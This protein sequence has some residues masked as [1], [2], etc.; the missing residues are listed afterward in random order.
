MKNADPIV[1]IVDDDPAMRDSMQL[2]VSRMGVEVRTYDSAESYLDDNQPDVPGCLLL[3]IR[4]RGMTGMELHETLIRQGVRIPTIFIT[5]FGDVP[6]AVR[7]TR[8]GAVDFVEKPFDQQALLQRIRQAIEQDKS[9]RESSRQLAEFA[10][11]MARLSPRER[12]V[13]EFV[14]EGMT[15][16][17]IAQRLSRSEKTV[18]AHR[19]HMMKKLQVHTTAEVVR[20]ALTTRAS[21]DKG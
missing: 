20:K 11:L 19:L 13:L 10:Q 12:E 7:A 4:M 15:S 14:I 5:G 16:R 3:D 9:D 21:Q 17:Q 2:L 18:K 1:F 8:R 6:T